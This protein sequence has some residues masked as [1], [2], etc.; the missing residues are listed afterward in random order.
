MELP[1]ELLDYIFGLLRSDTESLIKCSQAH[2]SF[3]GIVNRHLFYHINILLFHVRLVASASPRYGY[4]LTLPHLIKLLSQKPQLVEHVRVLQID[5]DDRNQVQTPLFQRDSFKSL[6][7]I[8][9][10]FPAFESIILNAP[11]RIAWE[12][13]L[14]L[15][16]RKV[17]GRCFQLP[18]VQE[19]YAFRF[20]LPLHLVGTNPNIK[21]IFLS[22]S[23]PTPDDVDLP[24]LQL[25]S[26]SVN[27]IYGFS[28]RTFSTWAKRHTLQLQSLKCNY[29]EGDFVLGI[30]EACSNTL[31]D[32]DIDLTLPCESLLAPFFS[33]QA[34]SPT[35]SYSRYQQRVSM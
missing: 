1:F 31:T 35:H 21:F 20:Q 12:G 18:T 13:S 28:L 4:N 34:H 10:R 14:P 3:Y 15:N 30:L 32:L 33:T 5:F 16:F 6:A 25:R 9:P 11:N 22:G 26:L 17:L 24:L 2:R 7:S 23:S 8:L 27:D 29:D 19:V